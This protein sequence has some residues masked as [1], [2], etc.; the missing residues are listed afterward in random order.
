MKIAVLVTSIVL[1]CSVC[2]A[3]QP[4]PGFQE[5]LVAYGLRLPV[6]AEYSPDG[7]LFILEKNGQARIVKDGKLLAQPFLKV[8][9][10]TLAERG[11]L[12]MAFDPA[13]LSNH[14]VYL[15]RTLDSPT[16][17]NQVER[18]TA[19]GDVALVSSRKIL[20]SGIRADGM[21]H[22]AGCLR[23]GKDGKLYISVGESDHR[24]LAQDPGSLNGKILRIN[25][26]GTIPADN[27]FVNQAGARH[28]VYCYGL[29][30]PWRFAIHP[31]TG[32]MAIA[33]V[34]EDSVEEINIGV[35][36]GNY[37]WPQAEGPSTLP[38]LVNPIYSYTHDEGGA[39]VIAGFFYTASQFPAKFRDQ[40]FFT[41][42]ARNFI[43]TLKLNPTGGAPL[44]QGFATAV[45]S[46]VHLAP[47]PDGSLLTVSIYTGEIRRIRYVGG[48]N[49][50]PQIKVATSPTSG[51]SP[52]R[53]NFSSKG[54]YDPDGD[55]LNYLWDFGD[56]AN[57]TQPNTSHTYVA[58][59]TYFA[60]LTIHDSHG[61][62]SQSRAIRITVGDL[63]PTAKILSP[64][65]GTV[66]HLG[67][68]V[69]LKGT[70]IDPE[71]GPLPDDNLTWS[72]R[73]HHNDHFHP[74]S[75]GL[76]GRTVQFVASFPTDQTGAFSYQVQLR[77]VDS[78]GLAKAAIINLPI[79]K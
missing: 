20:V 40:L 52:L 44:V 3:A 7:R 48:S 61:A 39:A 4:L 71:E 56:G 36:G 8:T 31:N 11:L 12:G 50:Q 60:V 77:A 33:D 46:P 53:V 76:H 69:T 19:N 26:D 16:P 38:G 49:R 63:P 67:Q 15:Y 9:V 47:A 74:F 18:Y 21:I 62:V 78:A 58:N 65:D 54:S 1:F 13:F 59:G 14:F 68:T 17:T 10:N 28:E 57:S 5:D 37:G 23:F 30:N 72:I 66:V 32:V 2:T 35:P 6:W 41:D 25:P 22:N 70:G 45:D 42:F 24:E 51:L 34:G 55:V 73:L 79:Q 43:K 29:R 27:P 64:P 75:F